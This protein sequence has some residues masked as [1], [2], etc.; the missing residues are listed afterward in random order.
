MIPLL[1]SSCGGPKT[2]CSYCGD[3][4]SGKGYTVV[5]SRTVKV[6]TGQGYL[7]S[8]TC[9][10][11][12]SGR[13][14]FGKKDGLYN[15]WYENGQ[16]GKEGTFKNDI[17]EGKWTYWYENGQKWKEGTYKDGREDGLWTYWY[18]NGQKSS[19]VTWKDGKSI[20]DE[21]WDEDENECECSMIFLPFVSKFVGC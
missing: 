17:G 1:L 21:C 5:G 16:K 4:F 15:S 12:Q 8:T 11:K 7:C 10:L 14:Q 13:Y 6:K 20:S 18:E 9:A 3:S 2:T 19:E